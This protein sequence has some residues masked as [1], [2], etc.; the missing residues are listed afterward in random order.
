M[1]V[2]L[3]PH[4]TL[5]PDRGSGKQES[6]R[7]A[8]RGERRSS[9]LTILRHALFLLVF[10]AA[11]SAAYAVSDPAEM[12]PDPKQEARAVEIGRQLRCL[13]CQNESIE[14]SGADLARD[15]RKIVRQRVV[16]GDSDDQIVAWLVARYGNFVRLSPPLNA[17]TVLLWGSPVI[18]LLCGAGIVL[19]NRRRAKPPPPAPLDGAEAAKLKALL[20][21]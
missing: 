21:S 7:P 16:A 8:L 4:P 2:A 14:D 17:A 20:G 6:P 3:P 19:V 9:P 11:S 12:L 1:V 13:V 5:S 15:L 10:L 18:A